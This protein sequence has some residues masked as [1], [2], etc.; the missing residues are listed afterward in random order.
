VGEDIDAVPAPFTYAQLHPE[1]C[2]GVTQ[3]LLT[4]NP[5]AQR[6]RLILLGS[7]MHWVLSHELAHQLYGDI[8]INFNDRMTSTD[9]E[10]SRSNELRAD[11]FAF[12]ALSQPGFDPVGAL[13]A[14]MFIGIMGANAESERSSDHPSGERR[15]KILVQALEADMNDPQLRA[16]LKAD[17]QW[18]K[19]VTSL[20][21]LRQFAGD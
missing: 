19:F 16:Q 2:R 8:D 9:L 4:N 3:S 17:N 15:F 7:S 12:R 18:D 6:T 14:Y 13:P 1:Y 11:K 21:Q 5:Q 10:L 20:E